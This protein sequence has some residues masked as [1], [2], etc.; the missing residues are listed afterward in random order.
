MTNSSSTYD[1]PVGNTSGAQLLQ[2]VPTTITGI[3]RLSA[4]WEDGVTGNSPLAI[5]ECGT[6]YTQVS[7]S[8]EWHLRPANGGVYGI[9]AFAAG[10]M[11]LKGWNLSTFPGIID[12]QFAILNVGM[13]ISPQR[14]GPYQVRVALPLLLPIHPAGPWPLTLRFATTS[15]HMMML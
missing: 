2:V 10:D 4:S 6:S 3:S 11:T 1:F 13:E 8:G 14:V 15:I 5:T 7:N 12:N 9:G